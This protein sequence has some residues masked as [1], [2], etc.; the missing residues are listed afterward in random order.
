MAG[1]ITNDLLPL[2]R[3]QSEISNVF[4]DMFESGLGTRGYAA[5]YPGVNI[6]RTATPQT[7]TPYP[8]WESER[9]GTTL[10]DGVLTIPF[11][12]SESSEPR[13]IRV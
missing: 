11:L 10:H 7:S 13:R 3:L 1:R 4:T 2:S 5:T 6:W 12:K 9:V 8:P